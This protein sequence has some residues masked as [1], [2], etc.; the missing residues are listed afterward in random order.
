MSNAIVRSICE[1]IN[2]ESIY[3]G[4]IVDGTQDVQGQEQM[5]ICIRHVNTD[6]EIS[7]YFVGLYQVNSTTVLCCKNCQMLQDVL[8]RCQLPI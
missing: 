3:F 1:D 2:K 7:E 6:L 4:V 5:S 8:L